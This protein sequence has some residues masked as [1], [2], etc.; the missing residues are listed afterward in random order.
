[1]THPV[2]RISPWI[3]LGEFVDANEVGAATDG[4]DPG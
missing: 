4:A 3:A 1:M 2:V